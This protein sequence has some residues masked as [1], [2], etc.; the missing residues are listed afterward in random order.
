MKHQCKRD[1]WIDGLGWK[2][3]ECDPANIKEALELQKIHTSRDKI[4]REE[5]RH[6]LAEAKRKHPEWSLR[7]RQAYARKCAQSLFD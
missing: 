6:A 3:S 1:K 7:E 5:Y 4:A 2:C